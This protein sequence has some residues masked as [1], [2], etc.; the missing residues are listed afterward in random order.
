VRSSQSLPHCRPSPTQKQPAG[1][2]PRALADVVLRNE[3]P[4]ERL[5]AV[6][7]TCLD[8]VQHNKAV[9]I[10]QKITSFS[11]LTRHTNRTETF[12][13]FGLVRA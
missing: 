5:M 3:G 13:E 8:A 1:R 2:S 12:N 11:R 6:A 9:E 7:Q 4:L 10:V